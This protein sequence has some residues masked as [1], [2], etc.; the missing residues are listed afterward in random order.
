[1]HVKCSD[2]QEP[3]AIPTFRKSVHYQ[4]KLPDANPPGCPQLWDSSH[5]SEGTLVSDQL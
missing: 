4:Q 2:P 3:E 1:M 5:D